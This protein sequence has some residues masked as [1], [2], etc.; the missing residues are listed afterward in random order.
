MK[1]YWIGMFIIWILLLYYAI[2][3]L[4]NDKQKTEQFINNVQQKEHVKLSKKEKSFISLQNI[5]INNKRVLI[6]LILGCI[7][8]IINCIM[9]I[10]SMGG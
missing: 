3:L 10:I 9:Q 1:Y 4:V 6:P 8:S 2:W 7:I 5:Y